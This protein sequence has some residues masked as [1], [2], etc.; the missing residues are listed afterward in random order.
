M[1]GL[2]WN[3]ITDTQLAQNELKM[4]LRRLQDKIQR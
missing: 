4:T 1:F 2:D 3:T